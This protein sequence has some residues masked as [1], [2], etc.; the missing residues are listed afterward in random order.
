M[1]GGKRRSDQGTEKRRAEVKNI[2]RQELF[3]VFCVLRLYMD[4]KN[5]GVVRER[6]KRFGGNTRTCKMRDAR[7]NRQTDCL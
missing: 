7:K 6:R 5:D 2:E 3:F 1:G 4:G